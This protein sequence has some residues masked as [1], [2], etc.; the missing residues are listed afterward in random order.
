MLPLQGLVGKLRS[1]KPHG[2]AKKTKE[3]E[4]IATW[5]HSGLGVGEREKVLERRFGIRFV[6]VL[7]RPAGDLCLIQKALKVSE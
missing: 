3:R 6:E 5:T 4:N 7:V 2:E 1:R